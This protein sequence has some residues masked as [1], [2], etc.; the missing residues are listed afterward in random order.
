[1]RLL[2][3]STNNKLPHAAGIRAGS[4]RP[5]G[6]CCATPPIRARPCYGK[7]ELR[8]RQRITRPLRQRNRLPT[9][10][11]ANHERTRQDWIEIP[12]PAL[13]SE[14]TFALAQE[15]SQKNKH[16]SPRRTIEPTLLQGI[17]VFH[18]CRH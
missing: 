14:A 15:Q 6:A 11:S 8:P 2:A 12:A 4:A 17:L 16:H 7:T 18:Q 9:R 3:T 5:F 13:V 10:N 1:M